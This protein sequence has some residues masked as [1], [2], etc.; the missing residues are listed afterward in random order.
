MSRFERIA[1]LSAFFVTVFAAAAFIVTGDTPGTDDSAR[2]VVD[3][4]TDNKDQVFVSS[5]LATLAGV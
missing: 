2:Q 5:S 4:Y 3:F 1:P